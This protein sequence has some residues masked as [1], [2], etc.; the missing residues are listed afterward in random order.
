MY[1]RAVLEATVEHTIKIDKNIASLS[2]G[3]AVRRNGCPREVLKV[4]RKQ[5]VYAKTSGLMNAILPLEQHLISAKA[6]LH[7]GL[8][9]R[10]VARRFLASVVWIY[11]ENLA[12][13]D[14]AVVPA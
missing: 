3:C 5:S 6:S 7:R 9:S 13:S 12:V 10:A 2:R 1:V 11:C 8:C 4:S 14:H